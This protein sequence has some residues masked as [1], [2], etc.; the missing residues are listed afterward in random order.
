M[1]I[2]SIILVGTILPAVCLGYLQSDFDYNGTVD[3]NDFAIFSSQWLET[4]SGI[5][6]GTGG[7]V[8]YLVAS[9]YAP[10]HVKARADF[11]CDGIDDQ[12]EIQA[13]IDKVNY[14]SYPYLELG[15]GVVALSAGTFNCSA[16]IDLNC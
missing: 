10:A 11:V 8:T 12:I 5:G 6:D 7:T 1:R 14:S 2:T 9:S 3:F 13:A 16:A 4:D 15:G